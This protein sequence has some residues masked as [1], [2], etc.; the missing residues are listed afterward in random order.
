[1]ADIAID[2]DLTRAMA[3]D[4]P[5][6]SL[7]HFAPYAV[8]LTH[9]TVA[10]RTLHARARV[11]LVSEESISLALEPVDTFPGRLLFPV[12]EGSQLLYLRAIRLDRLMARHAR[13]DVW[14]CR[15]SG[16]VHV[17]VTERA[18]EARRFAGL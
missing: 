1:M 5:A 18:L 6:H 13:V 14:D 2:A 10:S 12:R 4:A 11:R 15:V 7:I 17:F 8:R 9:V 16:L 3:V